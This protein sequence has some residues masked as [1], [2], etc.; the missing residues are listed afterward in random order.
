MAWALPTYTTHITHTWGGVQLQRAVWDSD[1]RSP[2]FVAW[3]TSNNRY[4]IL[5]PVLT[6][7]SKWRVTHYLIVTQKE[8]KKTNKGALMS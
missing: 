6:L 8:K 3:E 4:T 7:V 5:E 1:V 2:T